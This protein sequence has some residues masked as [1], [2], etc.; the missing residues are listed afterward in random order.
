M[1]V[2]ILKISASCA[3][4]TGERFFWIY[5]ERRAAETGETIGRTFSA[6]HGIAARRR[7]ADCWRYL[8]GAAIH[9]QMA[10]KFAGTP[11][12]LGSDKRHHLDM[13]RAMPRR[14]AQYNPRLF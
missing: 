11:A 13:A 12:V 5:I 14:G 9:R 7:R 6:R 2:I 10:F 3:R 8:E 4:A 1:Y